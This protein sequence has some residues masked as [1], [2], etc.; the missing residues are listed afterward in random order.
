ME[1]SGRHV[2]VVGNDTDP[3]AMLIANTREHG[4]VMM[5]HPGSSNSTEKVYG[6]PTIQAEIGEMKTVVLFAHAVS[7]GEKTSSAYGKGKKKA[8]TLLKKN[9]LLRTKVIETFSCPSSTAENVCFVGGKFVHARYPDGETFDNMNELS[10]HV[11]LLNHSA[12]CY[13]QF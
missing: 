11:Q 2:M 5:L 1:L 6:I 12:S 13:R 8:Y 4:K 3:L 9:R 7:G 10:L